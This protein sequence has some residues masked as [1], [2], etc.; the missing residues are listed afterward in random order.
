[1]RSTGSARSKSNP[2]GMNPSLRSQE[3][4]HIPSTVTVHK[5]VRLDGA[6]TAPPSKS[7]SHRALMVAGLC[8]ESEILVKNPLRAHDIAATAN[9]WNCLGARIAPV[10]DGYLVRGIAK[11][12][13]GTRSIEKIFVKQ[14]GT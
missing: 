9:A 1:M 5:A 12:F 13:E 10:A 4:D 3:N 14:S 11:P 8:G 7:Y 2:S 6:V